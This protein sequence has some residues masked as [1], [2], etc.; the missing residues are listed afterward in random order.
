[1][2]GLNCVLTAHSS[3][4]E[5]QPGSWDCLGKQSGMSLLVEE[6]HWHASLVSEKFV[7]TTWGP[8]CILHVNDCKQ[9][10][11]G[12]LKLTEAQQVRSLR[13]YLGSVYSSSSSLS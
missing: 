6:Q 9:S 10:G 3:W 11:H 12:H 5:E 2:H 8:R 13:P 4:S 1:M 7:V